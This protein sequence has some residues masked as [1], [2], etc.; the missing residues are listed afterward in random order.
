M[1][2]GFEREDQPSNAS[3]KVSKK[4]LQSSP[5]RTRGS[6]KKFK[7]LD[8]RFRGNDDKGSTSVFLDTL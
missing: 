7:N 8:S 2:R 6:R 5:P 1:L 4:S 3:K